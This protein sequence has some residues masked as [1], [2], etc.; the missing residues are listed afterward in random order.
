MDRV[1]RFSPERQAPLMPLRPQDRVRM[2]V[3]DRLVP[4]IAA[5]IYQGD[6]GHEA[7]E[8]DDLRSME[9][10]AV[11]VATALMLFDPQERADRIRRVHAADAEHFA[12]RD[13]PEQ[14]V[15]RRG[16]QDAIL[17][18]DPLV[19]K[20]MR[21]SPDYCPLCGERLIANAVDVLLT[22][23]GQVKGRAHGLCCSKDEQRFVIVN[24]FV[25]QLLGGAQ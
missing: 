4:Q 21:T 6:K 15:A 18:G 9:S 23:S 2:Q 16:R 11:Y 22:P 20:F 14:D 3:I 1:A 5:L 24:E 10:R 12:Y 25:Y 17:F 13:K 7:A 19:A 8:L